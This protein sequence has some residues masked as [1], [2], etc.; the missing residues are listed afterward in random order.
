MY[1]SREERSV[2]HLRLTDQ[3]FSVTF[4]TEN[5]QRLLKGE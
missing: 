5:G 3:E 1:R 4:L 2:T